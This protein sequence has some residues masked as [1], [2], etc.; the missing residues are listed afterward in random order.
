MVG[1][2]LKPSPRTALACV[3]AL[4]L[5]LSACAPHAA[6]RCGTDADCRA[7]SSCAAEGIC[8]AQSGSCTPAC[9]TL[10]LCNG[11][12]CVPLK[13]VV[14]VQPVSGWLGPARAAV[15]VQVQA[16]PDLTLGSLKVTALVGG[17]AVASGS[18]PAAVVGQNSVTL[19]GFTAGIEQQ[20]T[21]IATLGYVDPSGGSQQAQAPGLAANIDS[22]P[23]AVQL[24]G[25]SGV[26][27]WVARAGADLLVKA[28]LTD[29]GSGPASATLQLEPCPTSAPACVFAGT[30]EAPAAQGIATFDFTVPRTVQAAGAEAP[31]PFTVHGRDGA[32]NE[33]L[34]SGQI[35][36]DDRPPTVA[37]ARVVYSSAQ[38]AWSSVCARADS[39]G[40]TAGNPCGGR[41]FHCGRGASQAQA[42]HVLRDDS[43]TVTFSATDCGAG[44]ASAGATWTAESAGKISTPAPAASDGVTSAGGCA[45]S[46]NPAVEFSFTLPLASLAVLDP[47]RSDGTTRVRLAQDVLDAVGLHGQ[48]PALTTASTGAG[49]VAVSLVRWR[50]Q[51]GGV[52]VGAPALLPSRGSA[53]ASPRV[54]VAANDFAGAPL[55]GAPNLFLL[56]G[57]GA[58]VASAVVDGGIGGDVAA[59]QIGASGFSSALYMPG[60][61]HGAGASAS[62][63]VEMAMVG[64]GGY[65]AGGDGGLTVLASC[66]ATAGSVLSSQLALTAP[67]PSNGSFEAALA[68]TTARAN[69]TA[70]NFLAYKPV[71]GV[72]SACASAGGQLV[73]LPASAGEPT[74]VSATGPSGGTQVFAGHDA[75]FSQVSFGS[76][77]FGATPVNWS[78][79]GGYVPAAPSLDLD[80]GT[81]PVFATYAS[82]A[83]GANTG[84]VRSADAGTCTLGSCWQQGPLADAVDLSHTPLFA[85]GYG[86]G[87]DDQGE[88]VTFPLA[89][90]GTVSKSVASG[91]KVSAPLLLG[92]APPPGNHVVVVQSDGVVR[93]VALSPLSDAAVLL[94]G[95]FAGRPPTPV[96]DARGTGSVLYLIDGGNCAAGAP[97]GPSWIWALQSDAPPLPASSTAWVRPGRD[98]C[99]T[100]NA[101]AACP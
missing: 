20:G 39:A 12:A 101:Q 18:V 33:G 37:L 94:V 69:P 29:Q 40:C 32:G 1:A 2:L 15:V 99:N 60:A 77:G 34:A 100:R 21:L 67:D 55:G 70:N 26:T 87:T 25:G 4:G 98:S 24:Q 51:L 74:G 17:A 93:S 36:V 7:G 43:V 62:S 54:V 35:L 68:V 71:A 46:S 23:P 9:P 63:E 79:D 45:A 3:A 56:D 65:G 72:S 52:G 82:A 49:V 42:D 38:P 53:S 88:V 11:G 85:G 83:L 30:P 41:G 19:S 80:G 86:F 48:S 27:S 81:Q 95:S 64:D 58:E 31:V 5:A 57:S 92:D 22:K 76:S 28:Q 44:V 91:A 75:G 89:G 10:D 14:S 97:C 61:V 78:A 50:A 73:V 84:V 8:I 16:A 13:P 59:G 6:G 96:A 66:P 90:G 47:A